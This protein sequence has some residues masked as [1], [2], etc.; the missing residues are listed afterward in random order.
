MNIHSFLVRGGNVEKVKLIR[1]NGVS[2]IKFNRP[3]SYNALDLE[4]LEKLLGILNEI[5]GN[6]DRIVLLTGEGKAFCAGGDVSMMA[7]F[8]DMELFDRLMDT[9]EQITLK[10]YLL[11]KIV[12]AAVNGSAAGLGM[13]IALNSDYIVAQKDAKFGM[14]FAGIGLIPDGGGHFFLKERLGTH[15]AKQ[16]IWSLDQVHGEEAKKMGF[17]DILTKGAAEEGA[18]QLAAKLQVSPLQAIIKT[19][20]IL[21]HQQK[22]V[23]QYFLR[24]EK[25][26]QIEAALTKDHRE[27]V[28][29]FL[30]KR[31]PYFQGK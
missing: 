16:F 27:G 20:M 25:R 14:L 12:I 24:E 21:H 18:L 28:R 17:V 2:T 8:K 11:P 13:S 6:N 4:T 22:E 10:L 26:E 9:L 1:E 30:E 5:E 7:V 23:L 3:D 15:Q 19:K 29:A 31:K